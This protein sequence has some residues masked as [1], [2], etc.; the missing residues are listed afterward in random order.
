MS[1]FTVLLY[2]IEFSFLSSLLYSGGQL[3][4]AYRVG[5]RTTEVQHEK[6]GSW[7]M[8]HGFQ[9]DTL[10]SDKLDRRSDFQGYPMKGIGVSVRNDE[11]GEQQY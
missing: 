8:D 7:T 6:G 2:S 3:S 11:C 1:R 4:S 10:T 9:G 5:P